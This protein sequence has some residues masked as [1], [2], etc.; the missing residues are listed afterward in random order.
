MMFIWSVA[1]SLLFP[2]AA[3]AESYSYDAVG[4]LTGVTYADSSSITYVYDANGNI[5]NRTVSASATV[6]LRLNAS[7]FNTAATMILNATTVAGNPPTVADIYVALQLP[8]G[9]LLVM[10]PDGSF[11]AALTPLLSNI[12]VPAFNGPIFTFTFSGAEPVGVYTWF[13][14]FTQPG[15]L[16]VIG[17]MATAPFS[18]AP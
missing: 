16:N 17:A 18:F 3:Y 10:Q 7:A 5:L 4:R 14:A 9:T 15:T 11:G 8:D 6:T 12:A 13:A 2:L 1:L